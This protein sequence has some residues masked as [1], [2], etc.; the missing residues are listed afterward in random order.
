MITVYPTVKGHHGFL[1]P[2]T[3]KPI[4]I[5]LPVCLYTTPKSYLKIAPHKTLQP[6]LL[7]DKDLAPTKLVWVEK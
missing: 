5:D 6:I 1:Y 3:E 2:D 7:E 4:A